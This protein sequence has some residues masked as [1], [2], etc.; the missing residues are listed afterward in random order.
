MKH[1]VGEIV[2]VKRNLKFEHKYFMENGFGY[3]YITDDMMKMRGKKV[4]ISKYYE[5]GTKNERYIIDGSVF[6]WT[7]E[8]F[9]RSCGIHVI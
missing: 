7:D 8:M 2:L 4:R 3:S 1:K 5:Q 6:F 9:E